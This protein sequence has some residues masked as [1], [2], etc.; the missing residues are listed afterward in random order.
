MATVNSRLVGS[1]S[2]DICRSL[3]RKEDVNVNWRLGL[4]KVSVH[5]VHV[6]ILSVH[7]TAC[8]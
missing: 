7:V 6:H 2:I 3:A 5:Y 4:Q 8:V 1:L